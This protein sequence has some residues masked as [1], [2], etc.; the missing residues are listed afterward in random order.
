MFSYLKGV[1]NLQ[2]V[3]NNYLFK[4]ATHWTNFRATRDFLIQ[5]ISLILIQKEIYFT[6]KINCRHDALFEIQHESPHSAARN[7]LGEKLCFKFIND[8]SSCYRNAIAARQCLETRAPFMFTVRRA[9]CW[10]Y[11][12][13]EELVHPIPSLQGPHKLRARHTTML[14]KATTGLIYSARI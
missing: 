11:L 1:N 13:M 6:L 8:S 4:Q 5:C 2:N 10:G 3:R 7:A 12:T 9:G 14:A